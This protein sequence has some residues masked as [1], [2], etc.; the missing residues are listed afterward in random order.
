MNKTVAT[1]PAASAAMAGSA[2]LI[3]GTAHAILE[4]AALV[5]T[6]VKTFVVRG[7]DRAEQRRHLRNL[8]ARLLDD[9]GLSRGDVVTETEKP[10]W[11]P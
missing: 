11:R 8:D 2:N 5:A 6:D 7:M 10:F 4:G 3:L 9:I 1:T